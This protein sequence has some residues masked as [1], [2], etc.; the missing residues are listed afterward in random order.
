VIGFEF[1]E[2]EEMMLGGLFEFE[3]PL[4]WKRMMMKKKNSTLCRF[5]CCCLAGGRAEWL[6]CQNEHDTRKICIHLPSSHLLLFS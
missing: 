5:S 6:A 1:D 2:E 4:H 3:Q